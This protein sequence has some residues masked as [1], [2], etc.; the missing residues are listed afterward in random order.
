M[1]SSAQYKQIAEKWD[2]SKEHP[3]VHVNPRLES[4]E[5]FTKYSLGKGDLPNLYHFGPRFFD[6]P[7]NEGC[8]EKGICLCKYATVYGVIRTISELK[9]LGLLKREQYSIRNFIKFLVPKLPV[10]N[11]MAFTFGVSACTASH[12]RHVDDGWNWTLASAATSIAHYSIRNNGPFAGSIFVIG[13][14][15]GGVIQYF[16]VTRLGLSYHVVHQEVGGYH[17][18]GPHSWKFLDFGSAKVPTTKY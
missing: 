10:P 4:M 9:G 13:S 3:G 5:Y 7:M 16:R 1:T 14:L 18:S 8:I 2:L 12:F 15:A 17:M 11:A 6:K